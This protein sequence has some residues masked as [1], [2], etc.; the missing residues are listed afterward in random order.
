MPLRLAAAAVL[1]VQAELD[2]C[3]GAAPAAR[4]PSGAAAAELKSQLISAEL[5]AFAATPEAPWAGQGQR[6]A[7]ALQREAAQ[8]AR[9]AGGAAL[10][11]HSAAAAAMQDLRRHRPQM[12]I[13]GQRNIWL[14]KPSYG[15]KGLGVRL[16]NDGLHKV[17]AERDS[18]RV[19]QKYVERPLLVHG[20]KFD[21]RVWCLVTD[22]APLR[23]WLYD[24][25]LLRLCSEP[26]SLHDLGNK[27]CH[28]TNRS[29]QRQ[30]AADDAS[31]APTDQ[32]KTRANLRPASAST[33][34][35]ALRPTS[36]TAPPRSAPLRAAGS[37]GDDDAVGAGAGAGADVASG[38]ALAGSLM[39]S[40]QFAEHLRALGHG[41]AWAERVVPALR[42]VVAH[43][44]CSAQERAEPRRDSFEVYG[45]D[46]VLDERLQPWLIEVNESPNLGAHASSLKEGMLQPMLTSLV[47]LVVGQRFTDGAHGKPA[48]PPV[49]TVG[50]RVGGWELIHASECRSGPDAS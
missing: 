33:T 23:V 42:R 2:R 15:S 11:L 9:A 45:L 35:G 7:A 20:F 5:A 47:D 37:D 48:A 18:Q 8:R 21:I 28:I 27:F 22:W 29:V 32:D 25:C 10:E 30:Y 40:A 14:L 17:L 49:R 6:G 38:E 36:A 26:F 3:G 41:E 12:D 31:T 39:S 34:R 46:L 50:Q 44:M 4:A 16:L 13:D 19:V 24:D 43:T 1:A